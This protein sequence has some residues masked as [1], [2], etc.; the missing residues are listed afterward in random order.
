MSNTILLEI[1]KNIATITLN[2]P[3]SANGLNSTLIQELYQT[4]CK[5]DKNNSIKII[6]LTGKDKFFSAGGDL[7]F[8]Y[9]HKNELS[10][11]L[12][13]LADTFHE[14]I[15]ILTRM[16]KILIVAVNG[17]CAGAGFSL[18]MIGDFVYANESAKFVMA[19][20]ANGLS[21]DGASSYFLPR[22]IGI[23]KTMELMLENRVLKAQEALEWGLINKVFSDDH[24]QE[25]VKYSAYTLAS[26]AIQAFSSVKKLVH[27]SFNHNIEQQ[28]NL[29]SEEIV[30]NA[31][32]NQGQE[33][34]NAFVEKRKPKF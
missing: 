18:A 20:T 15:S 11:K 30:K 16:N 29:E 8:M 3:K 10:Q 33:G 1:E 5:I 6:I 23:R 7:K 9:D 25:Q 19:Y 31:I 22:I 26:G 32:S 21:P 4:V 28:M 24:F 17:V 2:R 14:T 34:I 12:K 13:T 27:V